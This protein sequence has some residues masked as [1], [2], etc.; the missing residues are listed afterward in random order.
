MNYGRTYRELQ[1]LKR[2]ALAR[3]KS[4]GLS[5]HGFST[6]MRSYVQAEHLLREIRGGPKRRRGDVPKPRPQGPLAPRPIALVQP[7]PEVLSTTES[8]PAV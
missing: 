7:A 1:D 5:A 3:T 8:P 6:L 2:D 4:D